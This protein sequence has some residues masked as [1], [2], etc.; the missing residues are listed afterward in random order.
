MR[1]TTILCIITLVSAFI[2]S[3]KDE[4]GCVTITG[5]L[6]ELIPRYSGEDGAE[7]KTFFYCDG[8]NKLA[9]MKS[10]ANVPC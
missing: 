3:P 9:C 1:L 5:S 6:N 2:I 7:I 8:D 10:H 4:D